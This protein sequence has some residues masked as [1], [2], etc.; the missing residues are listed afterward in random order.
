LVTKD[1][2]QF[3]E[4][5]FFHYHGTDRHEIR[6]R[7]GTDHCQEPDVEILQVAP[8][9]ENGLVRRGGEP[10]ST[11]GSNTVEGFIY[12]VKDGIIVI[13][14]D[15]KRGQTGAVKHETLFR[16]EP[17][18]IAGEIRFSNGVVVDINDHSG[19][20]ACYGALELYPEPRR[21]LRRALRSAGVTVSPLVQ[22]ILK[23][24]VP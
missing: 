21:S 24:E 6:L 23:D 4:S 16:N 2:S 15:G 3:S 19:S 14:R 18:E 9:V 12:A 17:V 22:S 10:L 7:E 5:L 1:S 8:L 11:G 13:A 20:Y